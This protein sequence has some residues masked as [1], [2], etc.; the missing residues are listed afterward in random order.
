L[1][2]NV[3]DPAEVTFIAKGAL[4]SDGTATYW[5]ELV[6]VPVTFFLNT[7][8]STEYSIRSSQFCMNV[9][10]LVTKL[11]SVYSVKSLMACTNVLY[12]HAMSGD[13]HCYG[14]NRCDPLKALIEDEGE[15]L[16]TNRH[17]HRLHTRG[18][19]LKQSLRLRRRV[20]RI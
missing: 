9:L 12:V 1:S 4:K 2:K 20:D 6:V 10:I 15:D 17:A 13:L 19:W 11:V 3:F 5:F 7:S 18:A 8:K 16:L 14:A